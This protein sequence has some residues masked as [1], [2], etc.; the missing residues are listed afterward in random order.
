MGRLE[1]DPVPIVDDK[2][3]DQALHWVSTDG[4]LEEGGVVPITRSSLGQ[5]RSVEAKDEKVDCEGQHNQTGGTSKKVLDK[6]PVAL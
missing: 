6:I 1:T 3:S 5:H 4:R 2:W